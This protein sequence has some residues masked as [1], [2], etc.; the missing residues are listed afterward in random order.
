[1]VLRVADIRTYLRND[2]NIL[3]TGRH[4]SGKTS[5]LKQ[6][7]ELEKLRVKFFNAATMDPYLELIGIPNPNTDT[8][9]FQMMTPSNGVTDAEVIFID[10]PN[11]AP[12]NSVVNALFELVQFGSVNG[13]KLPNFKCVVA[14]VNPAGEENYQVMEMDKAFIDRFDLVVESDASPDMAYFRSRFG[15]DVAKALISWH[16]NLPKDNEHYISARRLE[17]IGNVWTKI[18]TRVALDAAMPPNARFNVGQ[19]HMD[20]TNAE[21]PKNTTTARK[22]IPLNSSMTVAKILDDAKNNVK[23]PQL[24]RQMQAMGMDNF[25]ESFTTGISLKDQVD[26]LV[27]LTSGAGAYRFV[28]LNEK[29]LKAVKSS[30]LQKFL[31]SMSRDSIPSVRQKSKSIKLVLQQYGM[32]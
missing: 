32:I 18:H 3:L 12:D 17:I 4:G 27:R 22:S 16:R 25:V 13:V 5:I 2:M 15:E 10:E 26:F 14:A 6:A 9:S 24:N 20:L 28:S 8:N 29:L 1:M 19:L 21:K 30:V 11:R 7:C 31:L 23:G